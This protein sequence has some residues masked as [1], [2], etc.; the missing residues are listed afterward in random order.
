MRGDLWHS[1]LEF[2]VHLVLCLLGFLAGLDTSSNHT[3]FQQPLTQ[4]LAILRTFRDALRND[5]QRA[6]NRLLDV[7]DTRRG[8]FP[9]FRWSRWGSRRLSGAFNDGL[10][11]RFSDGF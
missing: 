1:L 7:F 10:G 6:L 2:V 8:L 3:H 5:V 4:L 11:S 9:G